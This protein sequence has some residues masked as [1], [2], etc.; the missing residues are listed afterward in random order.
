MSS[1]STDQLGPA[2]G[3]RFPI[4]QPGEED[5]LD[6]AGKTRRTHADLVEERA[7]MS[8]P[9]A[10]RLIGISRVAVEAAARAGVLPVCRIGTRILV[11]RRPLEAMLAGQGPVSG[12]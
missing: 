2:Y 1:R 11:L 5:G 10:A 4:D 6:Q 12:D 3:R 7:T 8:I 9:E